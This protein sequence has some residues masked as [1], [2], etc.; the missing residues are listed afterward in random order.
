MVISS[1]ALFP[2]YQYP[3]KW[4]TDT[5][6]EYNRQDIKVF[7]ASQSSNDMWSIPNRPVL[8]VVFVDLQKSRNRSMLLPWLYLNLPIDEASMCFIKSV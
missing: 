1:Y 8:N 4:Q 7:T 3:A 2:F 6:N 5:S